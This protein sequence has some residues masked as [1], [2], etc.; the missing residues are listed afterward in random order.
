MAN[1]R[2][3]DV[4]ATLRER[5]VCVVIPTYDNGRT[6]GDVVRD[7]ARYCRD[8]IV[9]NDGCTDDT[10]A[11]LRGIQGIT[12][13]EHDRN[14]GKGHAL[15]SGFRKALEMG[16]AYAITLDG[17]GQ[18]S[19]KDIPAF[20]RSNM[21]NP[22]ALIVGC[23]NL[24]DKP[25]SRGARFA[26]KFSNFWFC[27]QTWRWLGDTQTG[28][29]L[30]PLKKLR[31]LSLLTSRYEAELELLVFA[32][33]NWVRIVPINVDV[34]YP[35]DRVSHF[36]PGA[37]FARI[38]VLNTVLTLLSVVYGLPSKIVGV[39]WAFL[40]TLYSGLFFVLSAFLFLG[41][42]AF[43]HVLFGGGEDFLNRLIYRISRFIMVG[44]GIPGT[45]FR[46]SVDP[47]VDFGR[48][49]VVVCNHQSHLDL[50]CLLVLTPKIVFLTN[51]WV[52]KNPF[53]GYLIRHAGYLRASEGLEALMP[54]MRDLVG[55]GYSIAVFPE[56]SR[57]R[58]GR[59]ERFHKGA[60]EMARELGLDVLPAVVYGPGAVLPLG[61][62]YLH[63]GIIAVE[64]DRA[65]GRDELE[66][67][68]GELRMQS[69]AVHRWYLG[70][71]SEL[72]NRIDRDV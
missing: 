1:E 67:M 61:S 5:G 46:S 42:A 16:F 27:V 38:S 58:S 53:Y 68:G 65:F 3:I 21:E 15:R 57:S 31:G 48:P 20:L 55:R 64:V 72:K 29:R 17:D 40:R 32:A 43:V 51:D 14:R 69:I 59:I 63:R 10:A 12:V 6:I 37:D 22:G 30:Y 4:A 44:H 36:R 39:L 71:Y 7:A 33:W 62:C 13:V 41:P 34:A 47:E 54:R 49:H 9:V 56:G 8:I 19:G 70:K 26:N 52:W 35:E 28:Y 2:V 60:F 50:M 66:A 18:H 11:V 25:L 23:R 45:K 24:R